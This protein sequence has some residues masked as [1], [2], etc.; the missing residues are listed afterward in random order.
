[1]ST[2]DAG[3][4]NHAVEGLSALHQLAFGHEP[5]RAD[6]LWYRAWS[7]GLLNAD[8]KWLVNRTRVRDDMVRVHLAKAQATIVELRE[9][10]KH[11]SAADELRR[12]R[13]TAAEAKLDEREAA[14]AEREKQVDGW[15]RAS[16]GYVAQADI[17]RK[18]LENAGIEIDP[19]CR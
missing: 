4:I 2:V 1:M 15:Q 16:A 5:S 17:L 14:V 19:R 7:E 13:I 3:R 11:R 8:D 9:K 12:A 6:Q 10:I 18:Q